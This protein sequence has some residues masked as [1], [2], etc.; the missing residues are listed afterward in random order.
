[1]LYIDSYGLSFVNTKLLCAG[2]VALVSMP[3][4]A[5]A[6]IVGLERSLQAYSSN[7]ADEKAYTSA[8]QSA[9]QIIANNKGNAA[10]AVYTFGILQIV[11]GMPIFVSASNKSIISLRSSKEESI[12]QVGPESGSRWD[13]L[14][15]QAQVE[16]QKGLI[17][18]GDVIG[19]YFSKV[20]SF[21]K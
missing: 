1:V 19:R 15:T 18:R 2:I 3:G 6:S 13:D 16:F 20:K 12:A 4:S 17:Y 7:P 8:I 10:C 11:E 14:I 21:C 9:S 5:G